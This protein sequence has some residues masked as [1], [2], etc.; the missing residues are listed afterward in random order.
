[1]MCCTSGCFSSGDI[2]PKPSLR[3]PRSGR[4]TRLLRRSTSSVHIVSSI[5]VRS[6]NKLI[7]LW[8]KK[9]VP[10]SKPGKWKH[11]TSWLDALELHMGVACFRGFVVCFCFPF[12]TTTLKK[13]QTHVSS[14]AFRPS[15]SWIWNNLRCDP[16]TTQEMPSLVMGLAHKPDFPGDVL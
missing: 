11:R 9:L 2:K 14:I 15:W 13:R 4:S 3:S 16:E 1:M 12:Q 7:W 5:S 8:L 6:Q 10:K